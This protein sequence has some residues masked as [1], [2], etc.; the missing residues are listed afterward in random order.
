MIHEEFS[1]RTDISR[2]RRYELRH[3][4]DGICIYRPEPAVTK[5]RCSSRPAIRFQFLRTSTRLAST[6]LEP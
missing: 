5:F 2:A 3:Q 4:R 1:F 6:A